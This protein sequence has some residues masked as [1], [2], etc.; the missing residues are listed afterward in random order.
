[1]NGPSLILIGAGGHAHACIDVIESQ[2]RYNIIGLVGISSELDQRHLGYKVIGTDTDL[3][4]LARIHGSA[5]ISVGQIGKADVR[6]RL[7]CSAREAGFDMPSI[8]SPTAHVSRHAS[9]GPGSIV[10]HGAVINAGAT[11]GANCIINTKALIEH[12]AEVGDHCHVSTGAIL[13]GGARVSSGS[14]IGSGSLLRESVSIG[15]RCVVGMG[16][17][18]RHDVPEGTVYLGAK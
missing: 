12:D 18:V 7:Y 1:M 8:I 2:N 16:V 13:N 3:R 6:E 11:V 14:F 5:I 4:E 17:I 10:M 9:I 15:R